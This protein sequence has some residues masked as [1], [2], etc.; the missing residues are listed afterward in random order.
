VARAYRLGPAR[1]AVNVVVTA[2]L[3]AGIG[4]RSTYLLTTTGRRTGQPRTTPV[5]LVQDGSGRWLVSPY[6]TVA[7]VWNVR[8]APVVELRRGGRRERLQ[9]EEAGPD[10]AGPVLRQYAR[11]IPVTRPYFDARPQ[12]PDTAFAAEAARHPVFRLTPVRAGQD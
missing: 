8:A 6:G 9:A 4:P 1:K 2:L 5:T 7:W 12:D 11:S 3:R 10:A